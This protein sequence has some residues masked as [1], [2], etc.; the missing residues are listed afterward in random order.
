MLHCAVRA[1]AATPLAHLATRTTTRRVLLLIQGRRHVFVVSVVI[2]AGLLGEGGRGA[3]V[4][5][6]AVGERTP[7]LPLTHIQICW[8]LGLADEHRWLLKLN[9]A[10]AMHHSRIE[11]VVAGRVSKEVGLGWTPRLLRASSIV[12][13]IFV[14]GFSLPVRP[15]SCHPGE[16]P[17]RLSSVVYR[18]SA[19]DGRRD[20][21]PVVEGSRILL[22]DSE[23]VAGARSQ[24]NILSCD[25]LISAQVY[26]IEAGLFRCLVLILVRVGRRRHLG[27]LHLYTQINMKVIPLLFFSLETTYL[28]PTG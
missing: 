23:V 24:R 26:V 13:D 17:K 14:V 5:N 7:V 28:F 22:I 8:Q 3:V 10:E 18:E 20:L 11:L 1:L 25:L 12:L 27:F 21:R 19:R 16:R 9:A 6:G 2:V 15:D 4:V